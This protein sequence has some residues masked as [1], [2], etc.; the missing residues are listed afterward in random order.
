MDEN[1]IYKHLKYS[2][3]N[4]LIKNLKLDEDFKN[5]N[6]DELIEERVDDIL[7][8]DIDFNIKSFNNNSLK[9][10]TNNNISEKEYIKKC[11]IDNKS[12]EINQDNPKHK[13]S[14]A[15]DRYE[16][17]KKA[18]NYKEFNELGGFNTD[19]YSDFR[20]GILKILD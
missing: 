13:D 14:S 19:Y 4:K 15:Y 20:K 8:D 10:Y 3:K 9:N 5:L 12:I 17:Y 1:N 11:M 18:T 6:I 16:R 2:L 7:E